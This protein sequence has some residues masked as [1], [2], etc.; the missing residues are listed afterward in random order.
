MKVREN[1]VTRLEHI[2]TNPILKDSFPVQDVLRMLR[3][4]TRCSENVRRN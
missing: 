3:C 2:A 1:D 4:P